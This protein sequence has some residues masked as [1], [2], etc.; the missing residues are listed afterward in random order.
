MQ[1]EW[2]K[3]GLSVVQQKAEATKLIKELQDYNKGK[4]T[5]GKIPIQ[6]TDTV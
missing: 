3:Q 4:D 5:Y 1:K 6:M 2:T